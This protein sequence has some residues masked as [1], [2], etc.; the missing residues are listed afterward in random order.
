MHAISILRQLF[1]I[2]HCTRL[3][4]QDASPVTFAIANR[5]SLPSAEKCLV[6][7]LSRTTQ[8]TTPT[9]LLPHAHNLRLAQIYFQAKP[10]VPPLRCRDRVHRI[11]LASY[12]IE[13]YSESWT[14]D[15]RS[16]FF[17]LIGKTHY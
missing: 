17:S 2:G 15:S 4:Y 16:S 8:N 9:R 13:A 5:A 11:K 14:T 3:V 7:H 6:M 10:D 1:K 12:R